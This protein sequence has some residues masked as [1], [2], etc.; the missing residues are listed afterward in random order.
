MPAGRPTDYKK[1][2]CEL[3][4]KLCLLG[5]KDK[6]IADI[7]GVSEQT[8]NTWKEKHPEFLE[9]LKK[10]KDIADANVAD[11]LYQR[12]MGYEHGD[13]ELKVV[14]VGNNMGSEVQEVPIRKYYPPDP[15]A[16][17][18]W[19]K[20]RQRDKWRDK[21]EIDQ[22]IA[23]KDNKPFEVQHNN[24][25]GLSVEDLQQLKTILSKSKVE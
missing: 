25:D 5:A 10:G 14:S 19:L 16:A 11:R 3:A 20:N 8:L 12:A 22:N 23:N 13:I 24:L 7:L 1:E 21:Q 6:E 18:F 9:A 17:I 4:Y 15:T 2:Y